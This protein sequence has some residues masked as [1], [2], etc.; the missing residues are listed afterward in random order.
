VNGGD[1]KVRDR[2]GATEDIVAFLD[3]LYAGGLLDIKQPM[4]G[5]SGPLWAGIGVRYNDA[6][7]KVNKTVE[8][9]IF[10]TLLLG[11][12]ASRK[13]RYDNLRMRP[14][15]QKPSELARYFSL[16]TSG[17]DVVTDLWPRADEAHKKLTSCLAKESP[18]WRTMP[19]DKERRRSL[20]ESE[21]RGRLAQVLAAI[22]VDYRFD[23]DVEE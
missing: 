17:D 8:E 20:M 12:Y 21:G 15:A 14:R 2:L 19:D 22:A 13:F 11:Y 18:S 4:P 1:P 7:I 3:K 16:Q 6:K 23:V 9:A 10:A 5:G